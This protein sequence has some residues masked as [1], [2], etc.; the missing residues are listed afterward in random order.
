GD[1][2]RVGSL[3]HSVWSQKVWKKNAEGALPRRQYCWQRAEGLP[4][5]SDLQASA[6]LAVGIRVPTFG[7]LLVGQVCVFGRPLPLVV[8]HLP[9]CLG[10]SLEGG[11]MAAL[12]RL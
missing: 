7:Y 5:Y 6:D 12:V 11:W 2:S 10:P 3:R 9:V 8:F 1:F 4:G